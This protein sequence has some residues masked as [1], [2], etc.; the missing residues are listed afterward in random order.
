MRW[1]PWVSREMHEAVCAEKDRHIVSLRAQIAGL[2]KRL[3]EPIAVTVTLPKDFAVIHPAQISKPGKRKKALDAGNVLPAAPNIDLAEVDERDEATLAAL[4]VG[5]LGRRAANGWELS[6]VIR[7][8]Q[9]EI[10]AA[11]AAK[12]RRLAL[13]REEEPIEEIQLQAGAELD[14]P[15]D[16][17]K[18]PAHILDKVAEAEGGE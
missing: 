8:I 14:E 12:R 3:A 2:E 10:R 17:S 13:E 16:L 7:G 18:V 15:V 5:K 1:F 11:K 6:Q 4:A 9:I